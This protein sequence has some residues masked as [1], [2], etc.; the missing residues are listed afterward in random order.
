MNNSFFKNIV[1]AQVFLAGFVVMALEIL[2]SRLLAPTFGSSIFVWGSLIGVFLLSMSIG[3]FF[4]GRLS[5][6]TP[7]GAR[8]SLIVIAASAYIILIPLFYKPVCWFID[9]TFIDE[10]WG[11]LIATVVIFSVPLC[12]LGAVSPYAVRLITSSV[13]LAGNS[14]GHLYS[15]STL[16]SF[17]GTIIAAF[18]LI[19]AFP[20]SKVIF[21]IGSITGL[22]FLVTMIIDISF[23]R[24]KPKN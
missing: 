18:Y 4:G 1:R 13:K 7:T 3:Y 22:F 16:G 23:R 11:S 2:G 5:L 8:L 10:R 17:L 20:V 12:L 21:S 9:L 24:E 15:I 14:A 19:P 6:Y